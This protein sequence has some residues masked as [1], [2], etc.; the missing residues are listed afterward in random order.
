MPVSR[1]AKCN[2]TSPS[3]ASPPDGPSRQTSRSTSPRSVN[4]MALPTRLTTIWR[5]RPRSPQT[6]SG[7]WGRMRQVSSRPFSWART[8]SDFI[9][10]PRLS[11]R[12]KVLRSSCSLSASILEKSRMSLI[13][14]SKDSLDSATTFKKS[15]CRGAR[16]PCSTSSVMPMMAFMGVR[17]SWLI[18]ARN[19]L[20]ARLA[21]SA[22]SLAWANSALV[23]SNSAV[24]C[25]TRSSRS[26]RAARNSASACFRWVTSCTRPVNIRRPPT[27]ISL[28]E[29]SMGKTVPSLRRPTTSRP[30]PMIFRSPVR[31]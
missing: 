25:R 12:S 20:L 18:L 4:L 5:S 23:R 17:I 6:S 21:A 9:V 8:A 26:S 24:R 29:R 31:R 30:M 16:L 19:A 11:T 15:R 27:W 3:A 14:R 7:T 13:S 2:S 1:T 10:S 22:A 28:M